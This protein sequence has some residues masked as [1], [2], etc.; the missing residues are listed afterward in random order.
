MY[1]PSHL[2]RRQGAQSLSGE[3]FSL[4]S[5]TK[6]V[7]TR[8]RVQGA[9]AVREVLEAVTPFDHGRMYETLSIYT[10]K[11]RLVDSTECNLKAAFPLCFDGTETSVAGYEGM[12][13]DRY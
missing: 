3:L 4:E 8:D 6:E 12:M 11:L 13:N 5:S 1:G 2:D 10:G 7:T 9:R